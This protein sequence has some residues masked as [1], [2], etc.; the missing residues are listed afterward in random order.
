MY[1]K[2][3]NPSAAPKD[4]AGRQ[5]GTGTTDTEKGQTKGRQGT[6]GGPEGGRKEEQKEGK[7]QEQKPGQG[8][9]KGGS[10]TEP[11]SLPKSVS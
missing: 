1:N 4:S 7:D 5:M 10:K 2:V 3:G 8:Q 11:A 9:K 6:V